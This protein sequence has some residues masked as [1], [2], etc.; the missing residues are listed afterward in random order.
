MGANARTGGN[1]CAEALQ[2]FIGV[3]QIQQTRAR[4]GLA[5]GS[6]DFHARKD[7]LV[8]NTRLDRADCREVL[9]TSVRAMNISRKVFVLQEVREKNLEPVLFER[10]GRLGRPA[11][12]GR[13]RA[14]I[15][16][17]TRPG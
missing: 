7:V 15:K 11:T 4:S 17:G 16:A 13:Q 8:N 9:M 6:E 1:G 12:D 5:L 3:P 10:L 14:A 2:A